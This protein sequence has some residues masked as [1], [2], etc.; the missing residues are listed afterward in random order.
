M[1]YD[2]NI[3]VHDK[4]YFPT[5]VLHTNRNFN[6]FRTLPK[7]MILWNVWVCATVPHTQ[8]YTLWRTLLQKS[9]LPQTSLNNSELY[10]RKLKLEDF[11]LIYRYISYPSPKQYQ[12][13]TCT[14][15]Q[16]FK[17]ISIY[18]YS[19]VCRSAG[20]FFWAQL[21]SPYVCGQLQGGEAVL[22]ILA[23][24][25]HVSSCGLRQD[26]LSWDTWAPFHMLGYYIP[27]E[28]KTGCVLSMISEKQ[29]W[30]QM[31]K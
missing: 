22:L 8:T 14:Q 5:R 31:T 3:L 24:F 16:Q 20:G 30:K 4:T 26:R 13:T 9:A 1:S 19:C 28:G 10:N 21:G 2:N 27:S 18:H 17:T 7:Q 29:D 6:I 23:G 25:P 12:V 11:L 15:T